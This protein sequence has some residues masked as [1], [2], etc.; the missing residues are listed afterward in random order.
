MG[1]KIFALEDT[2]EYEM[3]GRKNDPRMDLRGSYNVTAV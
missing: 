2:K 3:L 1:S